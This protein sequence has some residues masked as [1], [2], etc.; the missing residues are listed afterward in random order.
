MQG[1]A[2]ALAISSRWAHTGRMP[3]KRVTPHV[4]LTLTAAVIEVLDDLAAEDAAAD[5]GQ[6][7]AN[8]SLTVSRLIVDERK[9]RARKK[10][11]ATP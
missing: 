7:R 8:R 2:R 11:S 6:P 9:R 1:A 5:A 10:G 3:E 4:N